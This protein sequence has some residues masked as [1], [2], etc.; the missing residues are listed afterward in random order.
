[1]TPP[2]ATYRRL[3]ALAACLAA[4]AAA[5]CGE[6]EEPQDQGTPIP[7]AQASA[8]Q[9][10]LDSIQSRYDVGGGA[11]G[12]ITGGADPNTTAVNRLLRSV[13]TSVSADVRSALDDSFS[14]LF[15]LVR[16]Q[17]DQDKGQT[18]E[19]TETQTETVPPET[20][21]AETETV[22]TTPPETTPSETTPPATTPEQDNNGNGV[23][24][25]NGQ[26]NGPP[27]DPGNSE[28]GGVAPE[29]EE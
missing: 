20:V 7:A 26:G 28:G 13:P 16:E 12:D 21:T 14:R 9:Q 8:L 25:R 29:D 11:C 19:T 3:L 27:E 23:G 6:D 4:L 24:N 15:Q 1:M 22:P 10:Q 5:G 17:C 2:S 18:T